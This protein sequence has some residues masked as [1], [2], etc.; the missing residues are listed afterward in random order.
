[1]PNGS[2]SFTPPRRWRDRLFGRAGEEHFQRRTSDWIRLGAG[3]VVLVIAA[4]HA[5][6]V[7]ASERAVFD[8]VN[9]LPPNL[10]RCSLRSIGSARSGR[11]GSWLWLRSLGSGGV[12]RVTFLSRGS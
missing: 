10:S 8:L 11:W 6:D 9:T 3:I 12:S 2:I 1:M 5:G 7:T 4:R